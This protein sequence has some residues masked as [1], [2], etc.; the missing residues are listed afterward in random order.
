MGVRG[1]RGG[2]GTAALGTDKTGKN[3]EELGDF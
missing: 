2:P 1:V 3:V